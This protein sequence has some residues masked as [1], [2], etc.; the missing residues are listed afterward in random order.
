VGK[1][2]ILAS[3]SACSTAGTFLSFSFFK[4]LCSGTGLVGVFFVSLF[5][6]AGSK[7][8][9][10]P[11]IKVLAAVHSVA[12]LERSAASGH[13]ASLG[14]AHWEA[15]LGTQSLIHFLELSKKAKPDFERFN[16]DEAILSLFSSAASLYRDSC[17]MTRN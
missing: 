11:T 17:I 3:S 7:L 9:N 15:V 5:N 16:H 2:V 6:M 14:R 1:I 4:A 12:T 8:T 13:A 10:H